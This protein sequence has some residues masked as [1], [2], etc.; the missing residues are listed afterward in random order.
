LH[1]IL[2]PLVKRIYRCRLGLELLIQDQANWTTLMQQLTA[3]NIQ[4][5]S[6][7]SSAICEE[8]GYR[9]SKLLETK[10]AELPPQLKLQ[11]DRLRQ[12]ED[13]P[14]IVPSLNDMELRKDASSIVTL[15]HPAREL[16]LG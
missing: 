4:I 16:L 6:I 15:K 7:H 8:V 2:I 9:L 14:S 12:K 10:V 1:T 11:L 5:D 3:P 13:A